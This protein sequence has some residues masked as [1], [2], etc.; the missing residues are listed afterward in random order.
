MRNITVAVAAVVNT[1]FT[2]G[3]GW[4]RSARPVTTL[5]RSVVTHLRKL[6]DDVPQNGDAARATLF[7][8]G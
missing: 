5:D 1:P 8:A 4:L 3:V 2:L 6:A 7:P